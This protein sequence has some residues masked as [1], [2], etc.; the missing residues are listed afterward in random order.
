MCRYCGESVKRTTLGWVH[1]LTGRKPCVT[2]LASP[3]TDQEGKPVT[4]HD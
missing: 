4:A 3:Y 2:T 1:L